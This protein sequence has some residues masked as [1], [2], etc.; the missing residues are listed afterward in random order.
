MRCEKCVLKFLVKARG[1]KAGAPGILRAV[2]ST[3]K[4]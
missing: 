1:V 2:E 4:T 3:L